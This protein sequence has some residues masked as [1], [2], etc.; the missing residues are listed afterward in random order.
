LWKTGQ[1]TG[2]MLKSLWNRLSFTAETNAFANLHLD[3]SSTPGS[4]PDMASPMRDVVPT[5]G[6]GPGW[7]EGNPLAGII[8]IV[9]LA[10]DTKMQLEVLF[11]ILDRDG[12]GVLT[13][14]DF[15]VVPAPSTRKNSLEVAQEALMQREILVKWDALCSEFDFSSD[16]RIAPTEFVHGMKRAALRF[17]IDASS[18]R[19]PQPNASHLDYL[20]IITVS[21]N[22]TIKNLCKML[23]DYLASARA[24][25]NAALQRVNEAVVQKRRASGLPTSVPV[26]AMPTT[27]EE[28]Q[29]AAQLHLMQLHQAFISAPARS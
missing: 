13:K 23:F 26:E 6:N 17:P 19:S 15:L 25:A 3:T 4:Q 24:D 20:T 5:G 11:G 1:R 18:A 22:A 21:L 10:E 2:L 14:E 27:V 12:S 7:W 9:P 29:K 28:Q 8:A 16:N